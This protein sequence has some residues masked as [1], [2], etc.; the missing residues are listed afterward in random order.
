MHSEVRSCVKV[1][2]TVLDFSLSLTVLTVSDV[3]Q[4]L[5]RRES[6]RAQELCE[7]R[8]VCPYGLCER[9]ATLDDA[10]RAHVHLWTY[11]YTDGPTCTPMD[12]HAHRW[13]YM[14]TDGPTCTP[15]DRHVHLWTYIYTYGPTCTPTDLHV[16]KSLVR[17]DSVH[18]K[19]Q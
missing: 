13:T 5:R 1:E 8:G 10:L 3:K 19:Q 17:T 12:L 4:H 16:H 14:Y 11:M 6:L 9:K 2:V 7:S 18:V 15:M